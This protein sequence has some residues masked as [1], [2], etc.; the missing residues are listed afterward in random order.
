[1][2][3]PARPRAAPP[4]TVAAPVA[5]RL[6]GGLPAIVQRSTLTPTL[7]LRAVVAGRVGNAGR[8]EVA[9]DQPVTGASSLT[10]R[11]LPRELGDAIVELGAVVASLEPSA[12][13]EVDAN[14]PRDVAR[15]LFARAL[16]GR[17]TEAEGA[18]PGALLALVVGAVEPEPTFEL[19]ARTLGTLAPGRLTGGEPGALADRPLIAARPAGA[20]QSQVG[21]LVAAPHP[22][23]PEAHAWRLALYV[24]AHGYEG[25]L[26]KEAIARRGLVYWIDADYRSDGR[27]GWIELLAG[28]DPE[29]REAMRDLLLA[30]V[31]GLAERPPGAEEIAEARRHLVGRRATAAQSNGELA[32]RHA[33][34]WLL[35]GRLATAGELAAELEG[36]ADEAVRAAAREFGKGVLVL[37]E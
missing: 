35:S 34:D 15:R 8:F 1:P 3:P 7:E 26:G 21:Y 11:C 16:G 27:R 5:R 14:R 17:S 22:G 4:A 20:V 18:A 33:A 29:K 19:L 28:I 9:T 6:A 32:A 30:E 10:L 25:R 24:L 31:R 36:V 37:V 13:E 23:S 2:P 12:A